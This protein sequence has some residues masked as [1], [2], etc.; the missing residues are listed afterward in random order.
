MVTLSGTKRTASRVVSEFSR[1]NVTLMAAGIAYNAFVSLAPLLLL[2]LLAVS[3]V[4]GGLEARVLGLLQQSFPTPIAN[5]VS[6]IFQ[7][8]SVRTGASI[9]S[10]AVLLWGALKV[11]RGLDTAFSEIYESTGEES[12]VDQLQ[13]GAIVLF[14]LILA[15]LATA[16]VSGAFAV[17]SG[18]VPY[19]GVAI[20]AA[21][22]V[23]LVLAF[24]PIYYLFPDEDLS[25]REVLPG[26]VFAAVGW[27]VL[28][29]AFQLYLSMKGGSSTGVFGGVILVVTWLYF[30]GLVILVGALI[31]AVVGGYAT[32]TLARA[33]AISKG[34][35]VR[36][37]ET[38][39]GE[40]RARYLD[41]L[42]SRV[43]S[44]S[45][46]TD[47]DAPVGPGPANDAVDVIEFSDT[48]DDSEEWAVLLRWESDDATDRTDTADD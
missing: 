33:E 8:E 16:A 47:R 28:Q 24:F 22:A 31:N 40:E 19:V 4:G 32:E 34:G 2:L 38:L 44:D 15:G 14:A 23:G 26:I 12:F 42:R 43:A 25:W 27:G 48:D 7:S 10:L 45:R 29:V 36:R 30:S 37:Q 46:G 20:P 17:F 21:L 5:V 41:R 3:F 6:S 9:A 18:V 35:N 39:T 1:K 13:D 11:F